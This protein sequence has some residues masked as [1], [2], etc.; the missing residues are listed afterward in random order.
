MNRTVIASLLLFLSSGCVAIETAS[1]DFIFVT[2]ERFTN[3]EFLGDL[4]K[5]TWLE[6]QAQCHIS[7]LL[8]QCGM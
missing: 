8:K 6:R 3:Q 2:P 1:A 7:L 4:R 5:K